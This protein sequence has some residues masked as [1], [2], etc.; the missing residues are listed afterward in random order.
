MIKLNNLLTPITASLDQLL[1]D[2]N[3]PR[4]SDFD[5]DA[6]MVP[7]SRYNEL[8]V[9]ERTF[10]RM[11][12]FDV[13]ELRDTIETVG[14]L[15]LDRIVVREWESQ[16]IDPKKYVVVEGN[17]R[18]TALK[19]LIML[20]EE[21]KRT[22][23]AEALENYR[24]VEVLLLDKNNAP[25]A[26]RLVLPGLRHVSGIKEWGPY[27][28]ARA[29]NELRKTG[30]QPQDIAQS[31]GLTTRSANALGRSYLAF[32][33][34][35]VDE[36][37]GE[38]VVPRKFS[39][40]EEI[41]KRPN[42]KEWLGWSDDKN[43]FTNDSHLREFYT[44]MIGEPNPDDEEEGERA[45]PKLPEAKSIRQLSQI[46]N[47]DSSLAI[48]RGPNG[49]LT[50]ALSRLEAEKQSDWQSAI[51]SAESTLATLSPDTLRS[52][53]E[54]DVSLLDNLSERVQKVLEDRRKLISED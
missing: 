49:T 2:P 51:G 31:L 33:Q 13:S 5:D 40:F 20:Q 52:M 1:L 19:W 32:E 27:Q 22:F 26:S 48:F 47:D 41:F 15:P 10:D 36:E 24:Q 28:K 18:V 46:L 3:N 44:W 12:E 4:F 23:S 35:R 29:V 34:M 37:Y 42:V 6:E 39:Y 25:L 54:E 38:F 45:S 14:F 16:A 8:K 53:T 7:E 50:R 9:Q 21:G 11:K 30:A 43:Q 17:R